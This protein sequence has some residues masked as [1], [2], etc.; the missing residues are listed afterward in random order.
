MVILA[1]GRAAGSGASSARAA[2]PQGPIL[3]GTGSSFSSEHG[4]DCDVF[5]R[6][7][8]D[9]G[10]RIASS[11]VRLTSAGLFQMSAEFR[12]GYGRASLQAST[13][14]STRISSPTS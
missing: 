6:C 7:R 5:V 3:S 4:P 12:N 11:T 9:P 2:G 8:W 10:T 13:G 1:A 14:S